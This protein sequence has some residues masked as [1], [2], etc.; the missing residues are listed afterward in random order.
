MT[1]LGCG[2]DEKPFGTDLASAQHL[3]EILR[4]SCRPPR[5]SA[6]TTSSP[7]SSSAA[8]SSCASSTASSSR[9]N[10]VHVDRVDISWLESLTLEGRASYYDGAGAL[11]DMVQN[12]LMEAMALVLMEQPARA[13]ADS[14]RDVRV[15]ALRTVATPSAE[16]MRNDTIRARYAAGTIGSR[17]VPSYVDDPGSTPAERPRHT[18]R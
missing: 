5:S 7:T 18:L 3:N 6:S 8:S 12:H 13:D 16:R 11:K 15:E 14:F 17:R 1:L 2:G 4:S 10:A 9:F